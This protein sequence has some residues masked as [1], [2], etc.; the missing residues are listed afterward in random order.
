MPTRGI[1]IGSAIT[2]I[3]T[4]NNK[5]TTA[6]F[7]NRGA[8]EIVVSE[9]QTGLAADGY[10]IGAGGSLD[11]IRAFGDEPHLAWFAIT[12]GGEVNLRVLEGFG[13]LPVM[14]EPPDLEGKE[15]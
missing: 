11:L 8:S 9:D 5:R 6:S 1:T 4:Y 2:P 14:V 12:L 3:L 13:M 10:P 7:T 15:A